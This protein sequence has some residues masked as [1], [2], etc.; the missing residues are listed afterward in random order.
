[1]PE[2]RAI[3]SAISRQQTVCLAERVGADDE[4]SGHPASLAAGPP[5]APP[6]TARFDRCFNAHRAEFDP[7]FVKHLFGDAGA[8]ITCNLRPDDVARDHAASGNGRLESVPGR[9]TENGVAQD[10]VENDTAI[11]G[12]DHVGTFLRGARS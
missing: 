9:Q 7:E 1:M 4:A 12:G 11:D 6:S 2:V 5:V 8:E 10:K 3:K